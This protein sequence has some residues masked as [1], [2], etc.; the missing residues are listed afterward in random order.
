MPS[1]S[2]VNGSALHADQEVILIVD[3]EDQDILAQ[4]IVL[5]R[6]VVL[7]MGQYSGLKNSR[8]IGR[9]HF[10]DIGLCGEYS[11]QIKYIEKQLAIERW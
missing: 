11:K 7:R 4:A 3:Q 10:V 8:Q 9:G 1:R 5:G 6:H 2:L